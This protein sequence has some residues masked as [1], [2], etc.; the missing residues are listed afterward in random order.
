MGYNHHFIGPRTIWNAQ[1][2]VLLDATVAVESC[3]ILR[4]ISSQH[5]WHSAKAYLDGCTTPGATHLSGPSVTEW[6][7]TATQDL[8]AASFMAD[9]VLTTLQAG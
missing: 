1:G 4:E 8:P 5:M 2:V 3:V 6:T 7:V 9:N